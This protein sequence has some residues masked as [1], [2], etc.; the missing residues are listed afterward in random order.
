MTL[1]QDQMWSLITLAV[2]L[3]ILAIW[4]KMKPEG[5]KKPGWW[6]LA[7]ALIGTGIYFFPMGGIDAYELTQT[8][9]HLSYIENYALW[10]LL[11]IT[12]IVAGI[13]IMVKKR[14]RK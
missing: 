2:F 8:T 5:Q 1:S 11:C 12:L 10:L 13:V 4:V 6:I 9:F 14:K 7:A 3:F